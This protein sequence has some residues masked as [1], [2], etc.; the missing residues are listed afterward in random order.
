MVNASWISW[1][2]H[3]SKNV[4]QL[5]VI[6]SLATRKDFRTQWFIYWFWALMMS[7]GLQDFI[8]WITQNLPPDYHVSDPLK[9]KMHACVV[10]CSVASNFLW[11]TDCSLPDS[12]VHEISQARTREWL[13]ISSSRDLPDPTIEYT[14]LA[15]PAR[16]GRVFTTEPPGKT[17]DRRDEILDN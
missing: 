8:V 17:N 5:Q 6:L 7:S 11:P 9:F 14:S 2:L 15:S 1:S 10:S 4:T 3:L 16:A 12:S 13:A